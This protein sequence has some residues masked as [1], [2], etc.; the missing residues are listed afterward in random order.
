[1]EGGKE[2]G[3]ERLTTQAETFEHLGDFGDDFFFHRRLVD[4]RRFLAGGATSSS[5]TTVVDVHVV[6]GVNIDCEPGLF[7]DHQSGTQ[8]KQRQ[9]VLSRREPEPEYVDWDVVGVVSVDERAGSGFRHQLAI[10][11]HPHVAIGET[12]GEQPVQ[13]QVERTV[14]VVST[15]VGVVEKA[16]TWPAG[17]A[18]LAES[19]LEFVLAD[20]PAGVVDYNGK[21]TISPP[22]SIPG[23]KRQKGK[24]PI[25]VL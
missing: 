22:H 18:V 9:V 14:P 15:Q 12:A 17:E 5:T 7:V 4:S 23:G 2:R 10:D 11:Q 3:I 20:D 16:S 19:Y 6:F 1:M 13:L 21:V 25:A 24:I 8:E